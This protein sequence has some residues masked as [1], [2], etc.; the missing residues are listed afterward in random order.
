M[1]FTVQKPNVED[2][3]VRAYIDEEGDLVIRD[4]GADIG[5]E[6]AICII[7]GGAIVR[8]LEFHPHGRHGNTLLFS[9]DSVTITF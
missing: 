3:G 7:K 8:G 2:R 4:L 9:G 1:K 6:E 5:E